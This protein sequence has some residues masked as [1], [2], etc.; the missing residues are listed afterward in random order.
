MSET[1][2]TIRNIGESI[3]NRYPTISTVFRQRD[4]SKQIQDFFKAKKHESIDNIFENNIESA[5]TILSLFKEQNE[6]LR[7][8]LL[9]KTNENGLLGLLGLGGAG[10]ILGGAGGAGGDAPIPDERRRPR[11]RIRQGRPP[12]PTVPNVP[13]Q[14]RPPSTPPRPTVPNV[15]QQQ[16]PPGPTPGERLNL[17]SRIL[18]LLRGAGIVGAA[19]GLL[20]VF[21]LATEEDRQRAE[22]EFRDSGGGGPSSVP[23]N[24]MERLRQRYGGSARVE[25]EQRER[26]RAELTIELED[27]R[28][29]S[30]VN[31]L[32]RSNIPENQQSL[33]Q[34]IITYIQLRGI[35]ENDRATLQSSTIEIVRQL[36]SNITPTI[37][38]PLPPPAPAASPPPESLDGNIFNSLIT[39]F[40]SSRPISQE[41]SGIQYAQAPSNIMSDVVTLSPEQTTSI[42]L[43]PLAL[44][45]PMQAPIQQAS[46]IIL[47]NIRN[48]YNERNINNLN[49][50][51]ENIEFI[52]EILGLEANQ[53][54]API[55][56][57][58]EVA[59]NVPVMNIQ[60]E[61]AT[62]Q[63]RQ[64][65]ARTERERRAPIEINQDINSLIETISQHFNIDASVMRAIMIQESGGRQNA[66]SDTGATGLFQFTTGTWNSIGRRYTDELN[67]LGVQ[68]EN[69]N[70][71][72]RGQATDPRRNARLNTIY[73]ALLLR[74]NARIVGS[75][76][77]GFLYLAHFL[78]PGSSR[79]IRRAIEN[80][81]GNNPA[82]SVLPNQ[83]QQQVLSSATNSRV[84]VGRTV[85]E[86]YDW[87]LNR[88]NRNIERLVQR[89]PQQN[90][91]GETLNREGTEIEAQNQRNRLNRQSPIIMNNIRQNAG[92][93][94]PNVNLNIAH[95]EIDIIQR[96]TNLIEA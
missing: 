62:P 70:R 33:L 71:E 28:L 27:R 66:I 49:F 82:I 47:P 57:Q 85:Q 21:G 72:N 31:R 60:R 24:L 20:S 65:S 74:E 92:Q 40:E 4:S 41:Q 83:V 38:I 56:T 52:G 32:I 68:H 39:G 89:T 58:R 2:N 96:F 5:D 93:Q 17:S 59:L 53:Q 44:V 22:E 10:G 18:S 87:A 63:R 50:E 30:V 7:R 26:E 86:L 84:V 67:A 61:F 69:V 43:P 55:Q 76:D 77:P 1:R 54:F 64:E 3:L 73:A 8:L 95:T 36:V 34:Q 94:Q 19:V 6:L 91:E 46:S 29:Q 14:Q 80:G 25:R 15:P 23:Q 79:S 81:L 78:G 37:S 12:R 13:Q 90:L 35:S 88:M 45:Q 48:D 9:E 42:P 75:N 51:A 11:R 16:R